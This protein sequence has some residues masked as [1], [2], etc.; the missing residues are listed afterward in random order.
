[1]VTTIET[2][3]GQEIQ[4]NQR[5][6]ARK[7]VRSEA[8]FSARLVADTLPEFSQ[9]DPNQIW[10]L[11]SINTDGLTKIWIQNDAGD[12][13][14]RMEE[15]N[16]KTTNFR[17]TEIPDRAIYEVEEFDSP[18]TDTSS[19]HAGVTIRFKGNFYKNIGGIKIMP[20]IT[21]TS[22]APKR[23]RRDIILDFDLRE[24]SEA[25]KWH[26]ISNAFRRLEKAFLNADLSKTERQ[27]KLF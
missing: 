5:P 19:F 6:N 8:L 3:Q 9:T 12:T 11:S 24:P 18:T 22:Q 17:T 14:V 4:A 2:A 25:D 21:D 10:R 7:A 23:R 20:E 16:G 27:P 26:K 13:K 1:M 15:P